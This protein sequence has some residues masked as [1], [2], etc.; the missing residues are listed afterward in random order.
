M[1]EVF[2]WKERTTQHPFALELPVN[3]SQSPLAVGGRTKETA[4]FSQC[5]VISVFHKLENR[6]EDTLNSLRGHSLKWR[7]KGC[8]LH[9]QMLFP[10]VRGNFP[11][12]MFARGVAL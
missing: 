7:G 11:T 6:T 2:F 4:I 5:F 1:F 9:F 8:F 12:A 10:S 3:T